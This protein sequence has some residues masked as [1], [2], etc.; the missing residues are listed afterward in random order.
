VS[1]PIQDHADAFLALLRADAELTV[2]DGAV[3]DDG[4]PPYALVYFYVET[5]DGLVAPDKVPLT[6]NSDVL[7][8][9]GYVH[10]VGANAVRARAVSGRVRSALLNK[11]LV[12]AGR[13]CF[14]IRW[15]Q[16]QPPQRDETTGPLVMDQVDVYSFTSIPA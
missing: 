13:E 7:E 10:C 12:I 2:H 6:F 9:W 1:W 3:P 11:T 16:G 15:R 4:D 5:P 14:P 8:C